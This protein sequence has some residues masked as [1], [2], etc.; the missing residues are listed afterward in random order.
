MGSGGTTCYFESQYKINSYDSSIQLQTVFNQTEFRTKALEW[1]YMKI[2]NIY[3]HLP[4]VSSNHEFYILM[5]WTN[6]DNS[7]DNVLYSDSTK[8]VSTHAVRIQKLVWK[9]PNCTLPT[10]NTLGMPTVNLR[11]WIIID[12]L[13]INNQGVNTYY[14]PGQ[15]AIYFP[16]ASGG[17]GDDLT[18]TI[19]VQFRGSKYP[20]T[21]GILSNLLSRSDLDDSNKE[22]IKKIAESYDSRKKQQKISVLMPIEK[23]LLDEIAE[24][25]YEKAG[26]DMADFEE[27]L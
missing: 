26:D 12:D 4:P 8:K 6:D 11:N 15:F 13:A 27:S 9:P 14:I 3:I 16:D 10:G 18:I 1:T 25:E 20:S 7:R 23:K 2:K 24:D 21:P 22:I 17:S 19:K 5:L